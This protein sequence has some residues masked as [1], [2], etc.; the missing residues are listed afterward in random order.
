MSVGVV[1]FMLSN[2]GAMMSVSLQTTEI[3]RHPQLETSFVVA[4]FGTSALKFGV[5]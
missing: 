3:F 5:M 4:V 2:A 1:G